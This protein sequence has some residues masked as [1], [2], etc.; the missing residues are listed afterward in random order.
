MKLWPFKVI[1][2][3]DDKP[4]IVVNYNDEEKQFAAE[5]I[6]S[7]ALAKMLEIAE[8][9]IGSIVK[10]VVITVPAYFNNSQR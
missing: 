7:M 2:G 1:G 4:M 6:S 9:Y 5:E 3:L 8:A 10:D